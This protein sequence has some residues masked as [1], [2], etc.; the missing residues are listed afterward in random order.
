[1]K[2][3]IR[4]EEWSLRFVT[5]EELRDC[6]GDCDKHNKTIRVLKTLRGRELLRVVAHEL[7]HACGWHLSE[8]FVDATSTD[9]A[10]ALASVGFRQAARSATSPRRPGASNKPYRASGRQR[11]ARG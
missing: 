2:I 4:D 7:L 10:A 5:G 11:S 8:A 9:M 1:M 6:L 3:T